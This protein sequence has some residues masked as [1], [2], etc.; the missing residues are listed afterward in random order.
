[1][2]R[3]AFVTVLGAVLATPCVAHAQSRTKWLI[4][5]LHQGSRDPASLTSAF[6]RGLSE[7]G[8]NEGQDVTIEHRYADGHYDRLPGLA[9]ELIRHRPAVIAAAF[10]P[11]SLAAKAATTTIPVVFVTGSDPIAAGLVSSLNRL[12]GN[13]TGIAFMFT[14]LEGKSLQLLHEFLPK[15]TV[16]GALANPNNPNAPP[17]VRDL[18]AAASALGIQL[19]VLNAGT[20]REIDNTF[21]TLAQRRV[22]ALIVTADGFFISQAQY[23]V[24]LAARYAMPTMYPLRQYVDA[25]GLM[26]YGA[27]LREAFRRAGSY[28]GRILKGSKPADLPVDQPTEF[29]LVINLKTAKALGVTIPPSLL[30]RADQVIE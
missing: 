19:T 21:A 23:L 30:L 22:G 4:G 6:S 18:Q 10:L 1:V 9:G 20:E 17:Q 11:A 8:L 28:V 24:T 27:N 29:E 25:G 7:V 26:S 5:F 16:V 12:T 15:A 13:V 14:L 2:N 3:R